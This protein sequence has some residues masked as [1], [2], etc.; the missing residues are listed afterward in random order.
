[1]YWVVVDSGKQF[2]TYQYLHSSEFRSELEIERRNARVV[3]K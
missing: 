1:L 2:L 3:H